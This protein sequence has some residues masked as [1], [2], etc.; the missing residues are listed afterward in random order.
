MTN[1]KRKTLMLG[2]LLL[3]TLMATGCWH[4]HS[5]ETH[6]RTNEG[7]TDYRVREESLDMRVPEGSTQYMDIDDR[8]HPRVSPTTMVP[9][10]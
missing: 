6:Y 7:G 8:W 3:T 9:Q 4:T 10:G 1:R 5:N 2:L